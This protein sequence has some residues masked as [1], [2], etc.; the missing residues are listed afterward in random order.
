MSLFRNR[1]RPKIL[2]EDEKKG[3][4]KR[5]EKSSGKVGNFFF[6]FVSWPFPF[7][8]WRGVVEEGDWQSWNNY[9]RARVWKQKG[10]KK[11]CGY[12]RVINSAQ[13]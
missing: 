10:Q 13:N 11:R 1:K 5:S 7:H 12:P 2:T 3:T 9:K 6:L 4:R 8:L